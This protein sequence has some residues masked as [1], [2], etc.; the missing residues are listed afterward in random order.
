MGNFWPLIN[1]I[2]PS[3]AEIPVSIKFLG[4]SLEIGFM[5]FP[6]ISLFIFQILSI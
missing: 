1:V 4:Y 2:N 3:I 6:F 5:A